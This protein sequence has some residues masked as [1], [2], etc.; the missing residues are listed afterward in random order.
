LVLKSMSFSLKLITHPATRQGAGVELALPHMVWVGGRA[1]GAG[2]TFAIARVVSLY[3]L[4]A[5]GVGGVPGKSWLARAFRNR[6]ATN[7]LVDSTGLAPASLYQDWANPDH[8]CTGLGGRSL[9]HL[10]WDCTDSSILPGQGS[11]PAASAAR[12]GSPR[13]HLHRDWAHPAHICTGTGLT[14][15]TSERGLGSPPP[16][17]HWDWAHP[18]HICTGIGLTPATPAPGQEGGRVGAGRDH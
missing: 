13:P 9:P 3:E 8:A 5:Y 11:S 16:H 6:I 18:G 2:V 15:P 17:L 14:P 1:G 7:A 4:V 10:R 12:L